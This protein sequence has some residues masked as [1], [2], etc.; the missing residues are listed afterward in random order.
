MIKFCCCLRSCWILFLLVTHITSIKGQFISFDVLDSL[1]KQAVSQA[2]L[3]I[4]Q[5]GQNEG[6]IARSF[7][8]SDREGVTD[9]VRIS[10]KVHFIQ[11]TINHI[12]YKSKELRLEVEKL[13]TTFPI[14][15]RPQSYEV[16]EVTVTPEYVE[17]NTS[18]V[19]DSFRTVRTLR[20]RE[21]VENI[22][23]LSLV[24]GKLH[25]RNKEVESLLLDSVDIF[26]SE[27][28]MLVNNLPTR[29]IE[30]LEVLEDYQNNKQLEKFEEGDLAVNINTKDGKEFMLGGGGSLAANHSDVLNVSGDVSL[31]SKNGIAVFA[32]FNFNQWGA[33]PHANEFLGEGSLAHSYGY[34][35]NIQGQFPI[36]SSNRQASPMYLYDNNYRGGKVNAAWRLSENWNAVFAIHRGADDASISNELDWEQDLGDANWAYFNR[37]TQEYENNIQYTNFELTGDTECGHHELY[38]EGALFSGRT[39]ESVNISG[40]LIDTFRTESQLSPQKLVRADYEFTR[41]VGKGIVSILSINGKWENRSENW[42]TSSMRLKDLFQLPRLDSVNLNQVEKRVQVN[43]SWIVKNQ[44]NRWNFELDFDAQSSNWET[45]YLAENQVI[46][47]LKSEFIWVAYDSRAR[48]QFRNY[49]PGFQKNSISFSLESGSLFYRTHPLSDEFQL[50]FPFQSKVNYTYKNL[51]DKRFSTSLEYD[52]D[53]PDPTYFLQNNLALPSFALISGLSELDLMRKVNLNMSFNSRELLSLWD[54]GVRAYYTYYWSKVSS[55]RTVRI[56]NTVSEQYFDE[57]Q[58]ASIRGSVKR[59]FS[60]FPL[61]IEASGRFM[62]NDFFQILNSERLKFRN[63]MAGVSLKPK[64]NWKIIELSLE[65]GLRQST[66]ASQRSEIAFRNLNSV[67]NLKVK[68]INEDQTWEFSTS[69]EYTYNYSRRFDLMIWDARI[70]YNFSFGKLRGIFHNL[71]D[72][73]LIDRRVNEI[74]SYQIVQPLIGRYFAI[75]FDIVI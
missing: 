67:S 74:S 75:Q 59:Y 29:F 20:L 71:F 4:E 17:R 1:T 12:Q 22:P 41:G 50:T 65:S 11:V 68:F 61:S 48:I 32:D 2:T 9:P 30:S 33:Y 3:Q 21:L 6:V 31:I 53:I 60:N 66:F 64:F 44:T 55:Q 14:L 52:Q 34:F 58:T 35:Q 24:S 39:A 45:R 43:Y 27:Y 70:S 42:V 15:L 57:A 72:Q 25:Y 16:P 46:D 19:A 63:K 49:L 69:A 8:F 38:A 62:F 13:E 73:D 47:E 51:N 40:D 23:D 56:E 28:S 26:G 54:Y 18:F 5:Y 37:T 10:K 36:M 7:V